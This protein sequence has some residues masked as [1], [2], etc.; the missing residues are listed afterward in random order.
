MTALV[1]IAPRDQSP[2][3]IIPQEI[4]HVSGTGSGRQQATSVFLK[5]GHSFD[6]AMSLD[7]FMQKAFPNKSE[8][9]TPSIES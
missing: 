7:D 9:N 3:F 5:N 6:I 8:A 4:V 2:H 1:R